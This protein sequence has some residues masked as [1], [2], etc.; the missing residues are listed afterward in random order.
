M[1]PTILLL[2]TLLAGPAFADD[3]EI[4]KGL[5]N[6]QNVHAGALLLDFHHAM[7]TT[8]RPQE[9]RDPWGTPY[10]IDVEK[11]RIVGAGSDRTFDEASWSVNEQFAG[12]EG[13]VVFQGGTMVRSNRNWLYL[14]VDPAGRSA[15]ELQA[16][17]KA[18]VGLML[19]R[20]P[21]MQQ[22]NAMKVTALAMQDV[23]ALATKY[24]SEHGDFAKL[25]AAA[26]PAA[27]LME[28]LHGNPRQFRDAWGTPL[29]LIIAGDTYRI[30]SAGG[31]RTFR[32]ETW[33]HGA[34]ADVAE[35][36]VLEN[37]AFTRQADERRMVN[38]LLHDSSPAVKPLTQP[39]D[40][41]PA[42]HLEPSKWQR[43]GKGV[44]APVATNR[45]EPVYPEE[46]R[47]MRI[48]GIVIL[49]LELS[50][51]G[52]VGAIRLLKSLAPD[53]DMAGFD[54]VRQW[55][56][57]P[58]TRDGKPVPVLFSLTINFRLK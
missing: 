57:Q 8:P 18:E 58:A 9:V 54:A 53:L 48:S 13:D 41:V 30:V 33:S 44:K 46:Y 49:E 22:L 14:H 17:R 24:R 55:K 37:G 27:L 35:D 10:R 1:K 45:I 42:S 56:F 38:A 52:E 2:I 6:L 15:A 29:R 26:D 21:E 20:T 4:A 25:A 3:A 32:P 31:D 16:L 11:D 5:E 19:M 23:G 43:V 51:T 47:R 39:P 28:E 12:T 34:A 50:E 36:T 40:P 7:G